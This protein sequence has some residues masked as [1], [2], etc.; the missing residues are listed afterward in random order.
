VDD[1][2]RTKA[3]KDAKD[4]KDKED[5]DKK[6]A[7]AAG[8]KQDD[9]PAWF[10]KYR[11]DNDAKLNGLLAEKQTQSMQQ[12]LSAN[13]K[14][15]GIDA[16]LYSKWALPKT[17][18]EIEAFADEVVS[19]YGHLVTKEEGTGGSFIPGHTRQ[20]TTPANGK[21]A[22]EIKAFIDKQKPVETKK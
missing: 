12:K 11:E 3:A 5:A 14:L 8:E 16:K 18:E 1:Y 2:Q 21:V 4:A 9:E 17:D 15:K 20:T 10:K 6:A 7:E 19:T 13:E 22:P